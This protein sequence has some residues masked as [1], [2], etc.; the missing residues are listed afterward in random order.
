MP[1]FLPP[2][3]KPYLGSGFR[4]QMLALWSDILF[5]SPTLIINYS[6]KNKFLEANIMVLEGKNNVEDSLE[7]I[8]QH[9]STGFLDWGISE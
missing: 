7:N 5:P 3:N 1:L 2:V 8:N 9:R 6:L 4:I